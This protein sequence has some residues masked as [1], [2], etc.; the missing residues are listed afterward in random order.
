M[1]AS[2]RFHPSGLKTTTGAPGPRVSIFD[3][4]TSHFAAMIALG[5][6]FGIR[7]ASDRVFVNV[8]GHDARGQVVRLVE[9]HRLPA[10]HD[11]P[12]SAGDPRSPRDHAQLLGGEQLPLGEPHPGLQ[13]DPAAVD[14]LENRVELAFEYGPVG[15]PG[16]RRLE[17]GGHGQPHGERSLGV[18]IELFDPRGQMFLGLADVDPAEADAVRPMRV[19]VEDV[20]SLVHEARQTRPSSLGEPYMSP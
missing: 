7:I 17:F 5:P 10:A 19:R 2:D 18:A 16:D 20:E 14:T 8:V 6:A 4:S 1:A 3:A 9:E 12:R 11:A 15:A 13:L